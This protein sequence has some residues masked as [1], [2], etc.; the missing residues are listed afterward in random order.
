MQPIK[1]KKP[2]DFLATLLSKC[3]LLN[4]ERYL[5]KLNLF[6]DYDILPYNNNTFNRYFFSNHYDFK[7]KF[8]TIYD[9]SLDKLFLY[10]ADSVEIVRKKLKITK[11][12]EPSEILTIAYQ[13]NLDVFN[14]HK[15]NFE[16]WEEIEFYKYDVMSIDNIGKKINYQGAFWGHTD[17]IDNVYYNFYSFIN[18]KGVKTNNYQTI[19]QDLISESYNLLNE[20]KNKQ[21]FYIAYS[22]LENFINGKYLQSVPQ[23]PKN[24]RLEQKID[25]IFNNNTSNE[26]YIF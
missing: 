5:I 10:D 19:Y 23:N 9:A 1:S 13:S 11:T 14:L 8:Q 15:F 4:S 6:P 17:S 16:R 25:I 7:K 12:L 18:L 3:H 26:I 21:S 2:K 20:E 24:I 22:A